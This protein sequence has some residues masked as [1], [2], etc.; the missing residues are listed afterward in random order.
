[1]SPPLA[2]F[3][4]LIVA[5]LLLWLAHR[6]IRPLTRIQA[7]VLVL[8]PLVFMGKALILGQVYAPVDI[9]YDT[10]PL[11]AMRDQLGMG[12]TRNGV[13][14][15]VYSQMIP[16]RAAVRAAIRQGEWPLWNPHMF[17]GDILAASAQSAPYWP[18]NLLSL[19]LPL[20][21]AVTFVAAITF[22]LAGLSSFL[23][24]REL[25]CLSEAALFGA[26]GWVL[27]DMLALWLE[28]PL[29]ISGSLL[30]LV[31]L[32]T[33]RLA[34]TPNTGGTSLLTFSL[35]L[36]LLSGHPETALHIVFLAGI[37]GLFVLARTGRWVA[38]A[39]RALVAGTIS[40][41]LSAFFILPI[42]E[43]IPQTLEYQTRKTMA[44]QRIGAVPWGEA[45]ELMV[46]NIVPFV[47]GLP[48]GPISKNPQDL[49]LP[50]SYSGSLVLALA[51]FGLGSSLIRER[52][53]ML[54]FV[55][56]GVLAGAFAPF[57]SHILRR[58]PLFNV[59][60]NERLIL[61]AAFGL[62]GLAAIGLDRYLR[63]ARGGELVLLATALLLGVA[64]FLLV[65]PMKERELPLDFIQIRSALLLVP[66]LLGAMVVS[67]FPVRQGAWL[68]IGLLLAQRGLEAA[69]RYPTLPL[70]TFYPETP[71]LRAIPRHGVHRM[72]AVSHIF[73]PNI[74]ALYGLEDVRGY[75]AMTHLRWFD[76]YSAWCEHIPVHFN[77]VNDLTRPFISF[78]NVKYALIEKPLGVPEG[79]R[80]IHE[81][82]QLRVV[83]NTRV[84]E[85][86]FVPRRVR[87]G[88]IDLE[89]MLVER[90][91]GERSWIAATKRGAAQPAEIENGPGTV[92]TSRDRSG[93]RITVNMTRPGWV[94]VSQTSWKGWRAYLDGKRWPIFVANYAFL[95]I[96]VPEGEHVVK[97]LY[98]P[99]SFSLGLS[100][101]LATVLIL[102][103]LAVWLRQRT[104]ALSSS[105]H[106]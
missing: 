85:R 73:I 63:G 78:L 26:S 97:L 38:F 27:G 106:T 66:L 34:V 48:E 58:L 68:L 103:A 16:W 54:L 98:R 3:A 102:I 25:G 95:G 77:R 71:E 80:V 72:T 56:L 90:D 96:P 53:P 4:Y 51:V 7:S 10:P 20:P 74:S 60:L 33:H 99:D 76:T 65:E 18:F 52:W 37:Y 23:F 15:D 43:A 14:S 36:L 59:A 11:S 22:F 13:L 50:A 2:L 12:P 87:L 67:L 30:P 24:L 62:I 105:A 89:Q 64:T 101:S 31:L 17:A 79:W 21:H 28:W 44:R 5:G 84:L 91:F 57:P 41:L 32:G 40:L 9:A 47:H 94:V 61:A 19:L 83:E 29:G 35:V 1:M 100:I 93:L 86:A 82:D 46:P 104:R 45:G 70:A 8:V 69:G 55:A 6:L 75:Q 39:W 42:L 92:S 49:L 88:P 81:S